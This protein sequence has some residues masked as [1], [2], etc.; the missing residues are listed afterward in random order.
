MTTQITICNTSIHQDTEGRYSLNDLHKAAGGEDKHQ[1]A[2]WIRSEQTSELI[3]E[4][5]NSANM[6]N[7][8]PVASK[9]GRFG[10]TYACKEL[11][12]AYAMWISAAFALKV[13]RAYDALVSGDIKKAESIAKTSTDE[14]TPLRDAV[15]MLVGKKGIMYPEAYSF[16]HQR[17]NVAHIEDLKPNQ[18]P[19]AVEYIHRLVIEGEFI[20]K[21]ESLPVPSFDFK[22]YVHNANVACVHMEKV[23]D[24]WREELR[25]S[26]K[27]MESPL[28]V[29][30]NDRII[31]ATAILC[32][33][34]GALERASGMKGL[35]YHER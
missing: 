25:P 12:Y 19:M 26:L 11:V 20:G 35:Q 22:M 6:Q 17:F 7:Y 27:A 34:R 13:I 10:G 30:L 2:F 14:R 3:T 1:P 4:I 16:I 21:Q 24:A 9:R 5:S 33:I 18:I 28:A 29:R 31:D 32:G 15:N 8:N 23:C